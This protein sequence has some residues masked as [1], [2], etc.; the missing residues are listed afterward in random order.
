MEIPADRRY[1]RDHEWAKLELDGTVVI[2]ITQFAQDQL[3]D[4]VYL[5]LPEEGQDFEAEEAFGVVESVKSVSDLVA[6]LSGTVLRVNEA[7]IDA[8]ETVNQEPYDAG[9]L[10]VLEPSDADDLDP[11]YSASD[12][13]EF[14]GSLG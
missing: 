11:L 6:P 4:V 12:Y 5:E 9:S 14:L 1:T 3:G 10:I 2:G 7:L 13:E 8:P